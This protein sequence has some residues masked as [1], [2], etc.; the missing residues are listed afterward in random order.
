MVTDIHPSAA[1]R[2]Q[3]CPGA[4]VP[5][6]EI[7]SSHWNGFVASFNAPV[8]AKGQ[9][10]GVFSLYHRT[11]LE[12]DEEWKN[13][14]NTLARQ[15]AIAVDNASLFNDLQH[16][17]QELIRAYDT[18]LEG[19]A[20]A[21]ELRDEETEGH[22][23]R[24]TALSVRLGQ[25][26]GIT[27]EALVH[28]RRGALLH[29]IGKM[30]LPDHILFKPGPLKPEEWEIMRQHPALAYN[31]LASIPFLRPALEIPYCHHEKWD[32]SGYP[33]GLKEEEIPLAARIFTIIDVWD[34]LLSDRPYRPA[35][36]EEKVR[37]YL[38]QQAG[39]HFDPRVV[40]AFFKILDHRKFF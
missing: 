12:P 21:L 19:W 39:I 31:L 1:E 32:G 18:T 7:G 36:S 10:K 29:D 11:P 35:W 37:Q 9:V 38:W 16:S 6:E 40:E 25:A 22:S 23:Q 15:T 17:N 27:A 26:M 5:V 24:V 13:F 30:S 14:L 33:R 20:K 3:V 28:L 4:A 34:A 2:G 8:I